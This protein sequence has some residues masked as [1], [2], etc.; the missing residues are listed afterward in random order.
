[1]GQLHHLQQFGHLGFNRRRIGAFAARHGQAKGDVIEHRHMAE[2]RIVLEN[3]AHFTVASVHPTD[4]GTVEADMTAGLMLQTGDNSQ[5]G[6]FPGRGP[7]SA[8]ICP[9]G[10]S[11]EISFHF[12][13]DQTIS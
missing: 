13:C 5:Q 4:V 11:N 12:G 6:G 1:M 2:Q 3:E 8:T 7:S 10:I 9:E